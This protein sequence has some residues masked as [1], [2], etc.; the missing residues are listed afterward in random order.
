MSLQRV[1]AADNKQQRVPHGVNTGPAWRSVR[2]AGVPLWLPALV[3]LPVLL[4]GLAKPLGKAVGVACVPLVFCGLWFERMRR[5]TGRALRRSEYRLSVVVNHAVDALIAIDE[6]GL[7]EHFNPASERIFGYAMAEVLGRDVEMLMSEPQAA[8]GGGGLLRYFSACE[9]RPDGTAGCEVRARRKDGST[10]PMELVL[11]GFA[12][13][14]GRYIPAILRDISVR[15]QVE[16]RKALLAAIVASSDDAIVSETLDGI[17]TSWNGSAERLLGYS[18]EEAVGKH[19]DLI[20]PPEKLDEE[21][22]ILERLRNGEEISAC[23]NHAAEQE[24]TAPLRFAHPVAGPEF[25]GARYRRFEHHARHC[26]TKKSRKRRSW[27]T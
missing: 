27:V 24:R 12:L 21:R 16:E 15:K 2:V 3:C 17:V 7:I 14:D 6:R 23:G 19:V 22:Q 5:K 8:E 10:F 25:G 20:I 9:A 11:S 1:S 13:K 18:A 26:R 4:F